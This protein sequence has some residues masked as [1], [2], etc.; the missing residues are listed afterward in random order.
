[1]KN[2]KLVFVGLV[3]MVAA[4]LVAWQG[5]SAHYQAPVSSPTAGKMPSTVVSG[6]TVTTKPSAN[7]V[8]TVPVV[9]S[10]TLAQV[11]A[12]AT[13]Q[14]CW[15]V[16]N[17]EV[18]DLTGWIGQHPGGQSAIVRLCGKDGSADF[19]DQHGGQRRPANELAGFLIGSLQS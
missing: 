2:K 9:K 7:S 13:S 17:G 18:Y 19:N 8:P 16:I 1:M 14:S 15:S 4:A 11:A 12:H 3:V 10:Y 6:N 5:S